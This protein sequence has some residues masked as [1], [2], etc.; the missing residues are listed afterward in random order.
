MGMVPRS[1]R[2]LWPPSLSGSGL[3]VSTAL[4]ALGT[5]IRSKFTELAGLLLETARAPVTPRKPGPIIYKT[6]PPS[7]A[8]PARS[9]SQAPRAAS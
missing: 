8:P 7:L 3:A 4:A 5:S 2:R 6:A 9:R 1:C